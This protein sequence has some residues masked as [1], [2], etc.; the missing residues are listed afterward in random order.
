MKHTPEEV[1]ERAHADMELGRNISA[2][3]LSAYADLLERWEA[4]VVRYYCK[5]QFETESCAP[6][7]RNPL[8]KHTCIKARIVKE[9]E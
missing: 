2:D 3:M 9:R 5:E 4:G 7:E 8:C 6:L 1:R